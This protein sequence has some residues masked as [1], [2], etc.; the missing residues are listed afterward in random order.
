MHATEVARAHW[1]GT[2]INNVS[3]TAVLDAQR[4]LAHSLQPVPTAQVSSAATAWQ[5]STC[6]LS[7]FGNARLAGPAIAQHGG[8]GE[9]PKT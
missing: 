1:P 9:N 8:C 7:M 2:I 4:L 6:M 5:Q 3:A